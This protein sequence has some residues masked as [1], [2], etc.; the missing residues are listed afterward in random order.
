MTKSS[1]SKG[2]TAI[3]DNIKALRAIK[4]FSQDSVARKLGCDYSTYGKIENGKSALTVSRLI[5]LA[6]IL[7]VSVEELMLDPSAIINKAVTQ[8]SGGI[9]MYLEIPLSSDEL[10]SFLDNPALLNLLSI[11]R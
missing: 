10:K 3:L 5:K 1:K 6:E 2:A 8:T 11:S 7:E 9:K 4:G